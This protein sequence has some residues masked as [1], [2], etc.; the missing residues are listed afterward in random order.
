MRK[1]RKKKSKAQQANEFIDER[2]R[3]YKKLEKIQKAKKQFP[4]LTDHEIEN[5]ISSG[6]P[7]IRACITDKKTPAK[8]RKKKNKKIKQRKPTPQNEHPLPDYHPNDIAKRWYG[9]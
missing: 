4:H 3:H 2:A 7:E 8:K 6:W 9:K 1:K 5:A